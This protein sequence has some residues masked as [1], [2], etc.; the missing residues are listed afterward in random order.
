MDVVSTA[1]LPESPAHTVGLTRTSP[2]TAEELEAG[3]EA[4]NADSLQSEAMRMRAGT[5]YLCG[6]CRSLAPS[7]VTHCTEGR[8]YMRDG[9]MVTGCHKSFSNAE[10]N[11]NGGAAYVRHMELTGNGY[12]DS[13]DL[14]EF[15]EVE[16]V[17]FIAP[18]KATR[19]RKS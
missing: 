1:S 6:A 19:T 3:A 2:A 4:A 11:T 14:S 5:N 16:G 18:P 7:A 10:Q 12:C 13:I 9:E 15:V 17:W 8:T